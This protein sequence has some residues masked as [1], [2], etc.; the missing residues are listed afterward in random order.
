[1]PLLCSAISFPPIISEI[2]LRRA[3]W[4]LTFFEMRF[5][6]R[7]AS[8]SA[9]GSYKQKW[10]L[11]RL[12]SQKTWFQRYQTFG[13][14]QAVKLCWVRFGAS[15]HNLRPIKSST[16]YANTR[17]TREVII[18]HLS[19]GVVSLSWAYPSWS[20]THSSNT[21]T[22]WRPSPHC[23]TRPRPRPSCWFK[24]IACLR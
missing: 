1:M 4:E 9:A 23:S 20:C 15:S 24:T 3:S 22:S 21:R 18:L 19:K 14:I 13:E 2:T 10:A 6:P 11:F 8:T 12:G 5:L 7:Q 16:L 17:F